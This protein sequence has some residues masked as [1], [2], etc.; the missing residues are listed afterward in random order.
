M[1]RLKPSQVDTERL[2]REAE[3][4]RP[5]R[6][7]A[8]RLRNNG[9]DFL[10]GRGSGRMSRKTIAAINKCTLVTNMEASGLSPLQNNNTKKNK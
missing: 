3:A 6:A 10:F 2:I 4:N 1:K 5:Q 7:V 9:N 8:A